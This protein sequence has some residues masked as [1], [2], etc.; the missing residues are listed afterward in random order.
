MAAVLGCLCNGVSSAVRCTSSSNSLYL[1][2]LGAVLKG[3]YINCTAIGVVNPGY[4][5]ITGLTVVSVGLEDSMAITQSGYSNPVY[6]AAGAM[7]LIVATNQ[8]LYGNL[9]RTVVLTIQPTNSFA[10]FKLVTPFRPLYSAT[11]QCGMSFTSLN[12]TILYNLLLLTNFTAQGNSVI[13]ISLTGIISEQL[14]NM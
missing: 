6:I 9:N 4:E 13:N 1:T 11:V 2:G 12:T 5:L 10:A 8:S 7:A 14:G 3:Q